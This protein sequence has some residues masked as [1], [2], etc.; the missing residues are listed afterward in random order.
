MTL[1]LKDREWK[2][3]FVGELFKI[4]TGTD[5]ILSRVDKGS[6]PV[7]SHS[8]TNNGVAFFTSQIDNRKIFDCNKTISLADRGNF[9]AFVQ[10]MDFYIGTRVKA[11]EAKFKGSN[12]YILNFI[13]PLINKQSTKFSYGNN[14]TSKTGSIKILLPITSS[15]NPDY[16]FMEQ[17]M[18]EQEANKIV[19][20]KLYVASGI[21]ELKKIKPVVPLSAKEWKEYRLDALF[22]IEHC[23]CSKVSNL[24]QGN[25]PYVGATN[26]NNGVLKFISGEEKLITKGNCIAFIC[27]GEG[28]IGYSI[29]KNEDFIGST[30]VKVGRSKFLNKYIGLFITTIADRV[31]SKYN[32]GFKR[33]ERHLKAEILLLP[34]SDDGQPDYEYMEQYMKVIEY[35]KL[36]AYLDCSN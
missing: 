1:S 25:I 36:K 27:D 12:L 20:F 31:Q 13:C 30:T 23:K 9:Y 26:R 6:I 32:F 11:L 19:Q 33:N 34:S 29:Y 28:S 8:I 16:V 5:L 17:Y 7:I 24:P 10:K 3:F 35:N 15:G 18:R 2:D 4:Y 21:K 22:Q 14:A